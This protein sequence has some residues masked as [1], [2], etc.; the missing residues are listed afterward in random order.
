M[1]TA[2]FPLLYW[3]CDPIWGF[4]C[5]FFIATVIS[6]IGFWVMN[7]MK[8]SARTKL[9]TRADAFKNKIITHQNNKGQNSFRKTLVFSLIFS[10]VFAPP[11][12]QGFLIKYF[13]DSEVK[14]F[15]V[16][17]LFQLITNIFIFS[18]LFY[19]YSVYE[20]FDSAIFFQ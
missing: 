17:I 10:L 15:I 18:S 2:F 14:S 12:L 13:V 6:Q 20:A 5:S 4:L 8:L 16:I 11:L 9:L 19:G 1:P 7:F 3:A